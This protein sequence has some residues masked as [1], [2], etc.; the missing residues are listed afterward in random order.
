MKSLSS[1]EINKTRSVIAKL[2]G[3]HTEMTAAV[4]RKAD[5]PVTSFQL[6]LIN[7]VLSEANILLKSDLPLPGFTQFDADDL[8]TASDVSMVVGQYV[9]VFEKIRCENIQ[10]YGSRWVWKDEDKTVTVAPRARK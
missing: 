1:T 4:K 5:A 7:G 2:D 8:P 10:T 9:E 3:L 6:K